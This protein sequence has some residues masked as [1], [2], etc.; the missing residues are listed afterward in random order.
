MALTI[1]NNIAAIAAENQLNITSGNLNSTLEQLS[2]GSRINSGADDP[3]GLAIANGLEANVAAL[4][5]SSSNATDGV[6]ELQVADGALS[7]VT[8]LLDR[9]VTLATESATGT[10]SDPQRIALNTEYQSIK[11][12]I[13]SIGSTT[14]FNGG[15]VFTNN[16]LNVFLS[17][18]STSGSSTIG[19]ST[20]LLSSTQLSLGGTPATATLGEAV[21]SSAAAATDVLTGG[22]FVGSTQAN[23][24]LTASTQFNAL[25]KA[26]ATFTPGTV[27]LATE[28]TQALSGATTWAGSTKGTSVNTFN[29]TAVGN[30]DTVA[31]GGTTYTFKTALTGAANE[32]L[33]GVT[34]DT[35][36]LA[37]LQ[38]AINL[39]GIAGTDYGTGTVINAGVS[40]SGA[41]ATNLTVTSK[42]NGIAAP[43]FAFTNVSANG[44]ADGQ[45]Q[46]AGLVGTEITAGGQN[47]TFVTALSGNTGGTA[48][49]VLYTGVIATDLAALKQAINNGPAG[50]GSGTNYSTGTAANANVTAGTIA[51]G[52]LTLTSNV[53]GV[54]GTIGGAIAQNT[55][56][57]TGGSFATTVA[58]TA[59]STV[60]VGNE[61]YTFVTSLATNPAVANEVV[62]SGTTATNLTNLAD[63]INYT[64]P[65]TGL[66]STA[67]SV[68]N[69][70]ASAAS[71]GTTITL[72]AAT[73]GI[74]NGTT[75][76]NSVA[77]S[78]TA[79][80]FTNQR[81]APPGPW[82]GAPMPAWLRL[83][84]KPTPS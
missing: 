81:A 64:A 50:T 63:A 76:G 73:D 60:T 49:E 58:G 61:T 23:S 79:G 59:G 1:L 52:A 22:T 14:N 16:T 66:Y 28:A 12:E 33:I 3:A 43:A 4:T 27:N 40:A 5:Q 55:A 82:L 38:K 54:S 80:T 53:N 34:G 51:S 9:A 74:G 26:A 57:G 41:S 72:T 70:F 56:G 65:N 8:T 48:N 69:T 62:G 71:S 29:A 11:A 36:A 25:T 44:A 68:A 67:N 19:V 2:S 75:T 17:D 13:D 6:G 45:V 21:A 15:Q 78:G 20:G 37:N 10:V 30:N 7:Q 31:V 42:V 18:G 84:T 32:V 35:T 77:V 46:T 83:A 39:S 47:Y 24:L